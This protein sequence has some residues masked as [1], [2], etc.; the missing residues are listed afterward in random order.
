MSHQILL[1]PPPGEFE[2]TQNIPSHPLTDAEQ[3]QNDNFIRAKAITL[4]TP[5]QNGD[6]YMGYLEVLNLY[7]RDSSDGNY[8]VLHVI[9][10]FQRYLSQEGEATLMVDVIAIAHDCEKLRQLVRHLVAFLKSVHLAHSVPFSIAATP[11]PD[12]VAISRSR[13]P[14]HLEQAI[15][16][17]DG[18][19][20]AYTG[21]YDQD[22]VNQNHIPL[23]GGASSS[24]TRITPIISVALGSSANADEGDT[25]AGIATRWRTFLRYFPSLRGKINHD[26]LYQYKNLVTFDVAVREHFESRTIAFQPSDGRPNQYDMHKFPADISLPLQW[27]GRMAPVSSDIRIP[28]RDPDFFAVHYQ[29]AKILEKT[30]VGAKIR[31]S[32]LDDHA[33][34]NP[35]NS[36]AV[37][38]DIRQNL[39]TII[40]S[41]PHGH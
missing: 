38:S 7:V 36:L 37:H 3:L 39:G 19:R 4:V 22:S 17:R 28:L 30:G 23:P 24:L 16:Q 14:A 1:T 35:N 26:S 8:D 18:Y 10:T 29:I 32:N 2:I 13:V 25:E 5:N 9:R 33:S 12:A 34:R 41:Q 27:S 21:K 31:E 40:S 15:L 6:L 11:N 20:C